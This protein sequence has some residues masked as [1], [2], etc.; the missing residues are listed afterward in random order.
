MAEVPATSSPPENLERDTADRG[1]D[2][3]M[4]DTEENTSRPQETSSSTLDHEFHPTDSQPITS[5]PH[6]NRKD[7]TL[8]EFLSKMDDYAPIVCMTPVQHCVLY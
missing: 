4:G 1:D 7:A 2:A 6:Q 3:E 5:T 8:K